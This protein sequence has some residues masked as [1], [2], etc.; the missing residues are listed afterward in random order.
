MLK[1]IPFIKVGYSLFKSEFYNNYLTHKTHIHK[2][3]SLDVPD[4]KYG[5][6][7][8]NVH[9]FEHTNQYINLPAGFELWN[10]A[11]NEMLENIPLQDGANTHHIT[12]DSQ[13]FPEDEYQ[14]REGIHIDG[15]FC[16]DPYF[17]H[18]N[19]FLHLFNDP[20]YKQDQPLQTLLGMMAWGGM[21]LNTWG[22]MRGHSFVY[23]GM[24]T[25]N[26]SDKY[27]GEDECE[28]E[29]IFDAFNY[30]LKKKD[31]DE[32][33]SIFDSLD[34]L[35]D[36]CQKYKAEKDNSH[37]QMKW[38]LPNDFVVPVGTYVSE[39][40][41]GILTSSSQ[42]GCQAWNGEYKGI[43]LSEGNY[44]DMEDQLVDKDKIIFKKNVLYFMSSNTPHETLLQKAGSRRTFM[45]IT[46][47]HN[48]DNT[49]LLD[50]F[51]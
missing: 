8:L 19:H 48:Y 30:E 13:Y 5:D 3:G 17:V 22:G 36:F 9:P 47:N 44:S 51:V 11:F 46:L 41:G 4:L 40:K 21:G 28:E 2:I 25:T 15:N 39:N 34:S 42:I 38:K 29:S 7:K 35:I 14:R 18:Q 37:V 16:M 43:V 50:N 1:N 24:Y 33:E 10:D 31:E 27:K 23:G 26:D 20:K 6:T 32:D 49:V 12:I 45:R